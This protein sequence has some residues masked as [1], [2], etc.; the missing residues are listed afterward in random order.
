MEAT[1]ISNFPCENQNGR[2]YGNAGIFKIVQAFEYLLGSTLHKNQQQNTL[3][4]D[5]SRCSQ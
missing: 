3:G 5:I 1:S 4:H 2:Y